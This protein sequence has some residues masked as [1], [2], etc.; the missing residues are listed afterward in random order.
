M[1]NA[2]RLLFLVTQ[3][4]W[5]G[6]QSFLVRFASRMQK[7][8]HT[9]LLA[10]AGEGDLWNKAREAGIPTHQLEKVTR[11]I[12]P[13]AD[14]AAIQEIY[15][16]YQHFKPDAIHLNSSKMGILGSI[17]AQGYR[18]ESPNVRIVYRIGGWSFLEPV[19][20]FKQ[21]IYLKA[22]QWTA[23]YKDIILTVH[24]DDEKLAQD[25]GIKPRLQVQTAVNGLDADS[26]QEQLISRKLAR[27]ELGLSDSDFVFGLVSN[28]YATKGLIPFIQE[29]DVFLKKNVC[30][31]ICILGDGPQ[32]TTLQQLRNRSSFSQRIILAGQKTN[33]TQLYRAFDAFVLPS[34]KEGMPWALLEAMASSLPC[35]AT[36]VGA[37]RWMLED[38]D[39]PCGM[40]VPKNNQTALYQAMQKLIHEPELCQQYGT[41]AEKQIRSR[42]SWERT[43]ESNRI[44]LDLH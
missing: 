39:T 20:A 31:S 16:L 36:D 12:K 5:G 21:W 30:V 15:A 29:I 25:L 8:G 23:K 27:A 19:G 6:V 28:A 18:K 14:I 24:P 7:E 44:A 26:F 9:V 17:A 40:I 33:A 42:F 38:S 22:E 13:S 11:D 32:F 2:K 35:I 34:K 1:P 41:A 10:A 4:H 3:A 43:V 37:C